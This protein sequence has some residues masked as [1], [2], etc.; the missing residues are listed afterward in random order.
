MSQNFDKLQ[1]EIEELIPQESSFK[2]KSKLM[3]NNN[4]LLFLQSFLKINTYLQRIL[5]EP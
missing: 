2:K 5:S 1:T 4:L 3:M